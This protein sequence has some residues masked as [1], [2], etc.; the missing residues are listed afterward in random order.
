VVRSG[1]KL[2][3]NTRGVNSDGFGFPNSPITPIVT[4]GGASAEKT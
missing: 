1:S 4:D 2:G 3:E